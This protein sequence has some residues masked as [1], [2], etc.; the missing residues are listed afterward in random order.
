M[1]CFEATLFWGHRYSYSL[2]RTV[3]RQIRTG[4]DATVRRSKRAKTQLAKT[5]SRRKRNK[6]PRKLYLADDARGLPKWAKTSHHATVPQK[7]ETVG[8][9]WAPKL[10]SRVPATRSRGRRLLLWVHAARRGPGR[11]AIS[12]GRHVFATARSPPRHGAHGL[13]ATLP[14]CACLIQPE[15][16]TKC[17][18]HGVHKRAFTFIF[19]AFLVHPLLPY[20]YLMESR[21]EPAIFRLQRSLDRNFFT[22]GQGA[23]IPKLSPDKSHSCYFNGGCFT[24]RLSQ[25]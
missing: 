4:D 7:R 6:P 12:A 13:S 8:H 19:L 16:R 17:F 11:P 10:T 20:F 18:R 23:E 2:L 9:G 15:G 3:A 5:S 22:K 14:H 25:Y 21:V 1:C 24:L